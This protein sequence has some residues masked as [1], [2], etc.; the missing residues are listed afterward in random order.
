MIEWVNRVVIGGVG[1]LM[2]SARTNYG[3]DPVAFLVIYL[4]SVPFFYYSIF[5]MV[6]AMARRKKNEIT[7][8]STIFLAASVAPFLY[9]LFFGHNLPWWAYVVIGLLVGQG[10][11]S[12]VRKLTKRT[13]EPVP[14][15]AMPPLVESLS[16]GSP[17]ESGVTAVT[18]ASRTFPS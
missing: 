9:V 3:V 4:A 16:V 15:R 18:A 8:W 14:A 13:G 5:R 1:D 7:L 10:T 11:Y 6:R 2:R 17:G 12:L